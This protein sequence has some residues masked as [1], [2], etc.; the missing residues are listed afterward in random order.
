[1]ERVQSYEKM[2]LVGNCDNALSKLLLEDDGCFFSRSTAFT[3]FVSTRFPFRVDSIFVV[4][5]SKSCYRL[6]EL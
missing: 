5:R 4:L 2:S 3:H 1:M 6:R